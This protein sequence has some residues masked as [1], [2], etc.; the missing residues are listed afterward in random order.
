M[1]IFNILLYPLT[2]LITF[3]S[4]VRYL[5]GEPLIELGFYFNYGIACEFEIAKIDKTKPRDRLLVWSYI[6]FLLRFFRICETRQIRP[7][8]ELLTQFIGKATPNEITSHIYVTI[9]D[10]LSENERAA[11]EETFTSFGQPSPP[12]V[13]IPYEKSGPYIG[14]YYFKIFKNEGFVS[15]KFKMSAGYDT[16]LLPLTVGIFYETVCNSLT[17]KNLIIELNSFIS[18]LTDKY[19]AN[20]LRR[21][22]D[23]E[24]L[25]I[26]KLIQ[27]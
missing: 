19:D 22:S 12:I 24:V 2:L 10:T 1:S 14:K 21:I 5:R 18:Y 27:R 3:I 15:S 11:V 23:G 4:N 8:K 16:I 17:D 20:E 25:N 7:V 13:A 6:L 9:L 26:L